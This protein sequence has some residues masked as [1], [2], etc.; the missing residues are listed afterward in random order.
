MR[1]ATGIKITQ[2]Q[3]SGNGA[4]D[5]IFLELGGNN[6]LAAPTNLQFSTPGGTPTL[7]GNACNNCVIEV[8]TSAT[9]DDGEGPRY[10]ATTTAIGTAFSLPI[11]GCDRFLTATARDPATNN[12]SPF[13]KPM[14]DAGTGCVAPAPGIQFGPGVP[15]SSSGAPH[16]VAPGASVVYTHLLTNTGTLAGTFSIVRTTSQG[17][18]SQPNPASVTLNPGQSRAIQVTVTVP[19]G[20]TPGTVDTTAVT[21]SVSGKPPVTQNDYTGVAQTFGVNI[22]PPTRSGTILPPGHDRLYPLHHEHRQWPGH[23]HT[24]PDS[25]EP[26][27]H[28]LVPRW[29][30]LRAS[31]G[32]GLHAARADHRRGQR[33]RRRYDDR[34]SNLVRAGRRLRP[35]DRHDNVHLGAH[36]ADHAQCAD[37]ERAPAG[38]GDLHSHRQEHRR[39]IWAVHRDA[40]ERRSSGL[41]LHAL[42]A[43]ELPA[44]GWR[45]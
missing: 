15:V 35:I 14:I 26:E 37:Q 9:R 30:K 18:A 34:E 43:D 41:E 5:G 8:F 4:G 16:L 12:T 11:P 3:T 28:R 39:R 45:K 22:D 1:I 32:R 19:P 21:A 36:T 29:D 25:H 40:S 23:N 31:G 42:A 17:W 27:C 20:T 10:L 38:D 44:H 33:Q 2:T 6:S 24:Q 13:T 7:S